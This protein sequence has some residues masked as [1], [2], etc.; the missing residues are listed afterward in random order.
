MI[1]MRINEAKLQV[2]RVNL[3][4]SAPRMIVAIFKAMEREM[5]TLSQR[6]KF[7][8]L[9]GQVLRNITGILRSSINYRMEPAEAQPDLTVIDGRVGIGNTAPYGLV[10]EF[11]GT[12]TVRP[13]LR[14]TSHGLGTWVREHT[15]TYPERPFMRP[16]LAAAR[17]QIADAIG[18]AMKEALR[19]RG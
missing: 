10:H 1:E 3:A 6:I 4:T 19:Q 8:Y 15:A 14:S 2:I 18:E 11:G 12:F 7:Q 16:A 13:Y 5:I 17:Q 9:S